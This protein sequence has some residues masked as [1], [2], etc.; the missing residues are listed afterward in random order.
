M[1]T[2]RRHALLSVQASTAP[3]GRGQATTIEVIAVGPIETAFALTT[4]VKVSSLVALASE[5]KVPTTSP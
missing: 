1:E 4:T 2:E 3:D 5:A